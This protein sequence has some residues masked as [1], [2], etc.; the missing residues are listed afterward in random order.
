MATP[1]VLNGSRIVL[2]L[3]KNNTSGNTAQPRTVGIFMNFSYNQPYDVSAAF[4][5]GRYSAAEIQTT[6]VELISFTATG[7]RVLDHGV[8]VDGGQDLLQDLLNQETFTFQLV[9]RQTGRVVAELQDCLI[10]GHSTGFTNKSM[11]DLTVTGVGLLVAEDGVGQSESSTA[12][13]LP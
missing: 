1:R 9:D 6:G 13:Q 11:S 8:F 4:I 7:W 2:Q 12:A 10:T 5:L 3:I